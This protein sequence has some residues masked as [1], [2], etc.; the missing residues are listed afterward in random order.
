[1]QTKCTPPILGDGHVSHDH[2]HISPSQREPLGP[3]KVGVSDQLRKEVVSLTQALVQVNSGPDNLV[4]GENQTV[5][6]MSAYAQQA[7]LTVDRFESINGKPMLIVTLP[8]K[9]PQAGAMG[10]VHHSDVVQPEG[11]WKL[12]QPFSGNSTND[13]AG[14]E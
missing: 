12:G 6:L 10:F 4:A 3:S 1:M 14:R 13:E 9:D 11:V 2:V 8:G 7:G 5:D